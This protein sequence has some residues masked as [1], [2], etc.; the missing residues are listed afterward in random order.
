MTLH[1]MSTL[2]LL[3]FFAMPVQAREAPRILARTGGLEGGAW[4]ATNTWDE[5]AEQEFS[6]WIQAVGEARE[7]K[8]FRLGWGLTHPE[9]NPLYTDE[10]KDLVLTTD[11]ANFPYALRAYFAYKTRRPFMYIGFTW[12]RYTAGNHPRDILDWT[13]SPSFR[14]FY[15]RCLSIVNTGHYRMDAALEATDTYPVEVTPQCVR[16]GVIYYDP[17][18]HIMVVYKVDHE[19][20]EIRMLDSHPDGTLTRKVLNTTM[21]VGSARFGGAFRAWRHDHVEIVDAAAETFRLVREANADA[22]CYSATEQYQGTYLVE[23]EE[24][25]YHEWVRYRMS[26]KGVRVDPLEEFPRRLS[27][28]CQSVADRVGAVDETLAQGIHKKAQ[29]GDL[30]WN[31]YQAAGE[32]EAYSSPGRDA[33]LRFEAKELYEFLV[34]TVSWA[35][36]GHRRL[37]YQ[38]TAKD[39]VAAYIRIWQEHLASD[40]CRFSYTNSA[41]AA[42]PITVADVFGRL[43]ALSFDPYH[44]PELRWGASTLESA[45]CPADKRKERWYRKEQRL[46]NRYT[47]LL[48][49]PT[50]D[51]RGPEEGAIADVAGLFECYIAKAPEYAACDLGAS[52]MPGK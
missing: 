16:P 44:C 48:G 20:G 50:W 31:I 51:H 26:G 47:R 3:L 25:T 17:S 41:G 1:R 52:P 11:C 19:T 36:K 30:P 18:G 46:R 43:Y 4:V 13:R 10:D 28:F 34:R 14:K 39:L 37:Q 21:N 45:T 9:A 27:G 15:D 6:A 35:E 12:K 29:P 40:A 42:V 33:R 24:L 38:G 5:A 2:A 22:Y 8:S 23:G 7:Q 49:K 32:W